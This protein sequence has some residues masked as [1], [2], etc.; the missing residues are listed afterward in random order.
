MRCG[1][2]YLGWPE[3]APFDA[4]LVTAGASEIPP[5]LIDQLA[6]GGRLVIP[7]ASKRGYQDLLVVTRDESGSISMRSALA[8]AFVP[9]IHDPTDEASP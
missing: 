4:I 6:P 5:P 8:V 1:D 2:G 7:V 9:L 3:R